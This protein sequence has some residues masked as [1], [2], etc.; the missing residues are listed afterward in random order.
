MPVNIKRKSDICSFV[1]SKEEER[2]S[3]KSYLYT[4]I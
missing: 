1:I 3:S 4:S 2:F